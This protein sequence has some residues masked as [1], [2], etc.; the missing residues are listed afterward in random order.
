MRGPSVALF[1]WVC[2]AHDTQTAESEEPLSLA[3][4][5]S[6][7]ATLRANLLSS[8]CL[9]P[10]SPHELLLMRGCRSAAE[11]LN[12]GLARARHPLVIC[13][14]QD[15]YLPRGWPARMWQQYRLARELYGGIGILGVYGVSCRN[16]SVAKT[17][18]VVDRERLLREGGRLPA[19]VDT[20]DELLLAVPRD[21]PVRFD[22]QL[23]FH[24]YGAIF[25]WR[26][27]RKACQPWPSTP[28]A[29]TILPTPVCRLNSLQ[30]LKRLL[31]SG[32]G[33]CL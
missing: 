19:P 21:A 8:P 27:R 12:R 10:G 14:H 3:V 25:V 7:E 15:V 13:V 11:G 31:P 28:C 32:H 9:G 1:P 16:G 18:C 2:T 20:L 17:G 22:P 29:F 6:N 24:F 33:T 23:G 30:A 5:V 4:C 26:P